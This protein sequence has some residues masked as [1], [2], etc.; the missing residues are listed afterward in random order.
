MS[1]IAVQ[2]RWETCYVIAYNSLH[3]VSY[4][5][6]VTNKSSRLLST[7]TGAK[8]VNIGLPSMAAND[9]AEN[10]TRPNF[11]R[12]MTGYTETDTESINS[13]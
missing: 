13:H 10:D 2:Q 3:S 8:S 1:E 9:Q 6:N 7:I 5:V 12:A 11:F 4:Q